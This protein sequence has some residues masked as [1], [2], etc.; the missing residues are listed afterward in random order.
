[1]RAGTLSV[2]V[3]VLCLALGASACGGDDESTDAS[4]AVVEQIDAICTDWEQAL[5]S[6]GEFPVEGFDPEH[7]SP[8]ELPAVGNF[9]A[10]GQAAAQEAIAK[11][12][13]LSPPAD[14]EADVDALISALDRRLTSAKEQASAA[15]AGDVAAFTA[16]LDEVDSLQ[17]EVKDAT[18]EVG[19]ESCAF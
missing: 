3:V 6:L 7:P 12:R 13:E 9:F 17:Q 19:A 2:T 15:Q 16:T 18:D 11:L 10:S 4:A 8:Q 5:D 1:V 14:I